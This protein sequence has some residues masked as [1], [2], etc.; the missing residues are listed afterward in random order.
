VFAVAKSESLYIRVDPA[1]KANAEEIY[2]KY[3]MTV[4]QAINVFL[5][6]SINVGGLPF[7]L[8]PSIPNETTQA[9]MKEAEDMIDGCIP[10]ETMS[11]DD[12]IKEMGS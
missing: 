7:D 1:V 6:Q 2:S 5:H 3:G 9:A 8:R 11:V 10:K 12:F 4:S